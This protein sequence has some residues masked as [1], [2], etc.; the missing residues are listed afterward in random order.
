MKLMTA[1]KVILLGPV[2]ILVTASA[3]GC[4]SDQA[5]LVFVNDTG[6]PVSLYSVGGTAEPA[7]IEPGG[8]TRF[9]T[10]TPPLVDDFAGAIDGR[11]FEFS[12]NFSADSGYRRAGSNEFVVP[13]SDFLEQ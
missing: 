13:L 12:I 9:A 10:T 8:R 1:V 7:L 11:S 4:D 2:L 3:T 5:L 6:N